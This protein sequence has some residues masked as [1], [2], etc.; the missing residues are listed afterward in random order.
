M[1]L[2]LECDAMKFV[3]QTLC[4]STGNTAIT[5][6]HGWKKQFSLFAVCDLSICELIRPLWFL[7]VVTNHVTGCKNVNYLVGV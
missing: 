1:T 3:V 4:V 7:I 2:I 5:Y 6:S